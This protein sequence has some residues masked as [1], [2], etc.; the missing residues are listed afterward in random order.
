M[1]NVSAMV[2][3]TLSMRPTGKKYSGEI[4]IINNKP[5]LEYEEIK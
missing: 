2:R 1:V 4:K 3:Y 5:V